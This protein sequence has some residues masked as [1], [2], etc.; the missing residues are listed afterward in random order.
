MARKLSVSRSAIWKAI[1]AL[2]QEGYDI[3]ASTNKGYRLSEG[4]D[5]LSEEGVRLFLKPGLFLPKLVVFQTIGSTNLEAKKM[6]VANA[7]HGTVVLADRQT[8]G[9][10]RFGRSFLSPAHTGIYMSLILKPN[11]AVSDAALMTVA[12]AVAVC[13]AVAEKTGL[14]PRVKWVNDIILDGK[15]ICGILTESILDLESRSVSDVIIGIGLNF[16][17]P[18]EYFPDELKGRAGSLYPGGRPPLTRNE[19]ASS[20]IGNVLDLYENLAGREFM[21][22]YRALSCLP[23]KEISYVEGGVEKRAAAVGI[24]DSGRLIVRDPDGVVSALSSGEVSVR[25]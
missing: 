21:S 23:G 15:K 14:A 10:G 24:D 12:A 11:L 7:S 5:V 6:A 17:T 16:C 3:Q 20:M 19:M 4:S 22:E 25:A 9:R 13:R 2:K 18:D 8:S 1:A